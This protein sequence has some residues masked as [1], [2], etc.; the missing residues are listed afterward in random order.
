M[1]Q[2]FFSQPFAFAG[3][4]AAIPNDAQPSGSVSFNQGFGPDYQAE[5]GVDPDAKPVPRQETNQLYFD[6][7]EN[8]GVWQR[9][10]TPEWITAANNGGVAFPYA[11]GVMVRYRASGGAAVEI[12]KYAV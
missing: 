11:R 6:I 10:G 2:K 4:K 9:Y 7:T 8:V 3:D 5:L 1:D 12:E